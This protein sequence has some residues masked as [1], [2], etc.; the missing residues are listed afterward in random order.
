MFVD[1]GLQVFLY[2]SVASFVI[3]SLTDFMNEYRTECE[4]FGAVFV[5]KP[6]VTGEQW[7]A[8]S[9]ATGVAIESIPAELLEWFA[10]SHGTRVAGESQFGWLVGDGVQLITPEPWLEDMEVNWAE[11]DDLVWPEDYPGIK[12]VRII[13]LGH[14]DLWVSINDVDS[15]S[16]WLHDRIEGNTARIWDSLSE[17]VT[18]FVS[19]ARAGHLKTIENAS[20]FGFVDVKNITFE[21]PDLFIYCLGYQ[22]T[23][24]IASR[25]L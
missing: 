21:L 16:V 7:E 1:L 8:V 20:S 25:N 2:L 11:V 19:L 13:D 22:D 9:T 15:G 6:Q 14:C 3:V 12:Q 10:W 4:K 18:V 23:W 5:E 24:G 17:M